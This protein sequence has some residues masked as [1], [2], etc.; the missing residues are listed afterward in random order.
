MR[1]CLLDPWNDTEPRQHRLDSQPESLL[2]N[3]LLPS[4]RVRTE[5]RHERR[6]EKDAPATLRIRPPPMIADPV[7]PECYNFTYGNWRKQEF[8]SPNYPGPYLNNTDCVLYL[9][10][11][12]NSWSYNVCHQTLQSLSCNVYNPAIKLYVSRD[13]EALISEPQSSGKQETEKKE[14]HSH[15][16]M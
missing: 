6:Q 5:R 8:Y 4:W 7:S 15:R 10:D 14:V 11:M 3:K 2:S 9:E 13:T 1:R 16:L 12:T